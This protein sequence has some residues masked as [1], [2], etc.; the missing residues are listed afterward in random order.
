M[1]FYLLTRG[2]RRHEVSVIHD[3]AGVSP[4]PPRAFIEPSQEVTC[5]CV[6]RTMSSPARWAQIRN[7]DKGG[8]VWKFGLAPRAIIILVGKAREGTAPPYPTAEAKDYSETLQPAAP[9]PTGPGGS[10]DTS[11]APS[12]RIPLLSL[13]MRLLNHSGS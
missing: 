10:S 1:G 7:W 13:E 9:P 4:S 6:C 5:V 11:L 8:S 12:P 2:L 3:S